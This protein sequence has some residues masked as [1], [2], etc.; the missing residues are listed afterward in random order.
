MK[1]GRFKENRDRAGSGLPGE[2]AAEGSARVPGGETF[3]LL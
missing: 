1:G 2:G 3:E